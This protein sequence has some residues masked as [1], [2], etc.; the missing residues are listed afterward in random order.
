MS[1]D[2]ALDLFT[3]SRSDYEDNSDF[4]IDD[5]DKSDELHW[6]GSVSKRRA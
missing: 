6:T 2:D 5:E 3:A 1:V 4:N